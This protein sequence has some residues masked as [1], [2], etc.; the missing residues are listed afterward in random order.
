LAVGDKSKDETV[1]YGNNRLKL[2][3]KHKKVGQTLVEHLE[4]AIKYQ[5][6]RLA[7]LAPIFEKI[8]P[9]ALTGFVN[10]KPTSTMR[11]CIWYLYE[12]LTQQRLALENSQA[13][14]TPLLDDNYYYTTKNGIRDP[15]TRVINNMLGNHQFCPMVRKTKK[16]RLRAGKD[17]MGVAQAKLLKVR[18]NVNPEQLGRSLEYLYTKE[19]KSSTDIEREDTSNAKMR[20]FY[21]VLKTSGT[22]PVSKR[23]LLDVQNEI[24]RSERKDDDYRHG[25]IYVGEVRP[26]WKDGFEEYIHFI[27][28][29][30]S[31]VPDLMSGWLD[32]HRSLLKGY[33]LPPMM[34]AAVISFGFVY[35]HPFNDGN[36]RI[37]RYLI[38]DVLKSRTTT[39]EDFIIPVSAAILQ[40][41]KQYDRVLETLS[42]SVMAMIDYDLDEEDHSI[43]I[44]NDIGFMYR[45][46]DLT[47]HVCFLY[48]MMEASI[49]EDLL[50]EIEYIV[51]YDAVK[52]VIEDLY[53]IPNNKLNLLI[54]LAIQ[55]DGAISKKKRSHFTNYIQESEIEVLQ[56]SIQRV[57][58]ETAARLSDST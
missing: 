23:R 19:T 55:N 6:V 20:K 41:E 22:V 5:G 10:E 2:L 17:L 24:V 1:P 7:Y 32:T 28:P 3:A 54:Q 49:G 29:R 11:R 9:K 12:F 31:D 40:H 48:D 15:R 4:T 57:L 26:T 43:K 58:E 50:Q 56:S 53:D 46:P 37:H 35:I 45:Y 34:H 21:R 36:G 42:K 27:G 25:E 39:E 38:H 8:D 51:K 13:S 16:I 30:A 52:R 44:N 47:D 18:A 14:Y 33:A